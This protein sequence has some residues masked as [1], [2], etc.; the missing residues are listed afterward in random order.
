MSESKF[1]SI[2]EDVCFKSPEEEGVTEPDKICPTCIPNQNFIEPDWT[3]LEE[4]YLNELKCE[5]QVKVVI[6]IDAEIYHDGQPFKANDVGSRVFTKLSDSPYDFNTLLKSYIRP[7]IRKMLR[8]YGKLET[9]QIVCAAP[10]QSQGQICKGIFGSSYEEYVIRTQRLTDEIVPQRFETIDINEQILI[11]NP[12]ITNMEALELVAR[13]QDY[14]F[15]TN[16]NV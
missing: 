16:Q 2:Q 3:L 8:F 1:K 15:I 5:Y 11:D 10:P 4:P 9:D 6:N 13:V 14:T 7:G 12:E